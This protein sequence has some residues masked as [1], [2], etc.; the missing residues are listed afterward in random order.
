MLSAMRRTTIVTEDIELCKK[1]YVDGL[2]LEIFYE[3]ILENETSGKLMQIENP[4]VHLVSLKTSDEPNGMVGL[5]KF[6]KPEGY[7]TR[8]GVKNKVGKTDIVMVFRSDDVNGL[9][10]RL[11]E[12]GFEPNTEPL[13][14]EIPQRGR[15][16][17]LSCFDPNGVL[18]EFT[19]Y[20]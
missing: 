20:L 12:L 5:M 14:Y 10:K 2:G 6:L 4:M 7:S 18:I 8:E 9:Y 11:K 17:A 13:E 3:N 1:F 19:Q 15:A 16:R